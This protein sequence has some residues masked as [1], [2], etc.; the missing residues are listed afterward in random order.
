[1]TAIDI[2]DLLGIFIFSSGVMVLFGR[3]VAYLELCPDDDRRAV[4]HP[5]RILRRNART[6]VNLD[7]H[8]FIGVEEVVDVARRRRLPWHVI[9]VE[10]DALAGTAEARRSPGAGEVVAVRSLGN[11]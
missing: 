5:T 6:R 10:L 3:K 8:Y 4:L 9:N 7:A 2:R 1:M 11:A